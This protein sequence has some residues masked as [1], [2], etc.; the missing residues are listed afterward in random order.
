[1]SFAEPPQR[2]NTQHTRNNT[3]S[4]AH[5]S[6]IDEFM[7]DPNKWFDDLLCGYADIGRYRLL[8]TSEAAASIFDGLPP[9]DPAIIQLEI[10][11]MD[12][13]R[14]CASIR[15]P[16]DLSELVRWSRRL[17]SVFG[18]IG[19]LNLTGVIAMLRN[20]RERWTIVTTAL[21]HSVPSLDVRYRFWNLLAVRQPTIAIGDNVDELTKFWLWICQN[22]G[23]ELP[24]RYLDIGLNGLRKFSGGSI[25]RGILTV[26]GL[27]A[28]ASAQEYGPTDKEFLFEWLAI[29]PLL[30]ND[31]L[32]KNWVK[33]VLM[34][35]EFADKGIV[36]PAWWKCDP[37]MQDDDDAK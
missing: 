31:L 27:A 14:Y 34:S 7:K 9:T 36:F 17:I 4:N 1:M 11:V 6:I 37:E 21:S 25:C 35:P 10:T 13:L 23:T 12:W 18:I 20:N 33:S 26:K 19:L 2:I 24:R 22:A 3:E 29:K 15:I 28:W 32:W 30:T 8:D 16:E 5:Q